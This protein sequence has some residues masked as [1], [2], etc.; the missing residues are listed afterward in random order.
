VRGTR[1][2][3]AIAIV[4]A[5]VGAALSALALPAHSEG[6]LYSL[7]ERYGIAFV[8]QV[9]VDNE[10][11]VSQTL[12]EYQVAPLKVG[13]YSDWSHAVEPQMPADEPLEYAQLLRV[14]DWQWDRLDWPTIAQAAAA[15]PGSIWMIG[16]EPECPNQ[17]AVDPATYAERYHT[18]YTQ[19]K[20]A[21]PTARIAN[22]GIVE[23]TPLR[24]VWLE[25]A[26]THYEATYGA[27]MPVD[28]W[29]IHIQILQEGTED[30]PNAGAGVPVGI[31]PADY[32]L[33][34]R[35]Y[36]LPDTANPDIFKTMIWDMREWMA[37]Q[38]QQSKP[39]IISEMG[40]LMPSIYLVE[41]GSEAERQER[42]DLRI[43]QFMHDVL[44][45][46]E[47]TTDPVVG[48][49]TDEYRL[50]QR[51]LWFSLN[52]SDWS[53]DNV[54]GFNGNLYDYETKEPTRFG[55]A[56]MDVRAENRI[57]LPVVTD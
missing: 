20:A 47:S 15:N 1:R 32:G 54:R 26:M 40:V 11:L 21:D 10:T 8:S 49:P 43:I 7:E 22:G 39:L 4:V 30:N 25:E 37:T 27:E 28:V 55:Y 19:I 5:L 42:G 44:P 52:G 18:A 3:L 17:D 2:T 41:G 53:D 6:P 33:V 13:W 12:G 51:W 24:L 9:P 38:G 16:N 34:P 36:V 46:L 57:H 23:V 14:S 56:L 29:N 45:W 35:D 48:M 31:N 50:V